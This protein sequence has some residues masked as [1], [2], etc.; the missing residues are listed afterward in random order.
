MN[1]SN[2]LNVFRDQV[3]TIKLCPAP[4]VLSSGQSSLELIFFQN[5]FCNK[6]EIFSSTLRVI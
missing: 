6:F 4:L 5:M 2:L 3:K 1:N